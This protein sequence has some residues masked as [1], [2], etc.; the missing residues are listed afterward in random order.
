MELEVQGNH[1]LAI[2]NVIVIFDIV[3]FNFFWNDHPQC[4]SLVKIKGKAVTLGLP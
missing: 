4:Q 3:V 1:I 2:T